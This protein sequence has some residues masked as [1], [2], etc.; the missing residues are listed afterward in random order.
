MARQVVTAKLK[1]FPA[2]KMKLARVRAN[3]GKRKA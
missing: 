3:I 1:G 2:V